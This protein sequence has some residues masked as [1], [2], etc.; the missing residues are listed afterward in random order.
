MVDSQ[1]MSINKVPFNDLPYVIGKSTLYR[2]EQAGKHPGMFKRIGGR[3]LV[4][5]VQLTKLLKD[6][7]P[8]HFN[9]KRSLTP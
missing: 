6:G 9:L 5:L 7:E 1:F 2:W 8:N 4:D 3:V